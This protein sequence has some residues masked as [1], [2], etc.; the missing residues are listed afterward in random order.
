MLNVLHHVPDPVGLLDKINSPE[1]VFEINKGQAGLVA[2]R[3]DVVKE[4]GSHRRG[5]VMLLAKK[6]AESHP[7]GH[8]GQI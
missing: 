1:A 3:F 4:V 2:G 7:G 8:T 5:R 6:K